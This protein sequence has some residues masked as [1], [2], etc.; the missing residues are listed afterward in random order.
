MKM[1]QSFALVYEAAR[2]EGAAMQ[3]PSDNDRPKEQAGETAKGEEHRDVHRQRTLKRAR[4]VLSDRST[5]DCTIRD[6]SKGG[7]RLV[8]GD[9]FELPETFRLIIVM[10]STIV[11]VRLQWQRGME[12]GV[13]FTGP[14]EPAH[15]HNL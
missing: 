8:F 3:Q 1:E 5:I 12:A 14:E 13:A 10:S 6:I 2:T 15:S 7:A 11:P 4:A 9:A